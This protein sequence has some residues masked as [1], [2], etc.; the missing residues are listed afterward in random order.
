MYWQ[1][2]KIYKEYNLMNEQVNSPNQLESFIFSLCKGAFLWPCTY[3]NAFMVKFSSNSELSLSKFKINKNKTKCEKMGNV[4]GTC[5]KANKTYLLV[6]NFNNI[7]HDFDHKYISTT[8]ITLGL[9]KIFY[10]KSRL[11]NRAAQKWMVKNI[12]ATFSFSRVFIM[13][14]YLNIYGWALMIR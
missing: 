10:F 1:L 3:Y 8:T 9:N 4:G 12:F 13:H 2:I 6:T 5:Y 11:S 7:I 14:Y